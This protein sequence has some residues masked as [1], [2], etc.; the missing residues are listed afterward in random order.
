MLKKNSWQIIKCENRS[1]S[2][3]YSRP[4]INHPHTSK[5]IAHN[6]FAKVYFDV[7]FVKFAFEKLAFLFMDVIY[8]IKMA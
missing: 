7:T 8:A 6:E 2:A 3:R 4:N 5:Y 1:T